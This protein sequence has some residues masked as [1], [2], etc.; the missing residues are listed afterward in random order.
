MNMIMK[1]YKL[2]SLVSSYSK[3]SDTKVIVCSD[4]YSRYYQLLLKAQLHGSGSWSNLNRLLCNKWHAH[5]I[6]LCALYI[7]VLYNN[8]AHA[9]LLAVWY[10]FSASTWTH[11]AS[12]VR[13]RAHR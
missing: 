7:I 1:F 8:Y 12:S 10:F 5:A 13:A 11:T 2:P 3:L 6:V 9:Q 4:I